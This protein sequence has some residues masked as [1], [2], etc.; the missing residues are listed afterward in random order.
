LE[1]SIL[2]ADLPLSN[3]FYRGTSLLLGTYRKNLVSV[4]TEK[5]KPSFITSSFLKAHK[6]YQNLR[7]SHTNGCSAIFS[8]NCVSILDRN[9]IYIGSLF[10]NETI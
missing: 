1:K 3:C 9:N 4:D 6:T 10:A 7:A 8:D 2:V 5:W